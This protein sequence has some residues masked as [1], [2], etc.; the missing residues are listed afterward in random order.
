VLFG[1]SS[2]TAIILASPLRTIGIV[3]GS[4]VLGTLLG[5]LA[6]WLMRPL[7]ARVFAPAVP[8]FSV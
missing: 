4:F 1:A 3:I 7:Q 8:R 5:F 2:Q 6:C